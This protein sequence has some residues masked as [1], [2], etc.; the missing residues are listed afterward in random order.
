[1]S[2]RTSY[3]PGT[4]CWVDL[5]T[6]DL[7]AAAELLRRAVRLGDA[8]A[9]ELGRNG[10]LPAGE[11]ERQ[12]RRRGDAADAGGPAAGLEHLRL[13][14]RR[15]RDRRRGP[16]ERRH[17]D[18]R[19]DGR[20]STTASWRSSPTPRAPSSG[21]GSPARF[22]GAE[23][24]NEPG[25]FGWNELDTRDTAAAKEFYGAVFGW[26]FE[27]EESERDGHY[28]VW[29]ARRRDRSAACST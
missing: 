27:D 22:A 2:E 9:A 17:G 21:S 13:G 16:G 23:L 19:A 15:R 7:E 1:M 10:R 25:A 8:G 3:A 6:P 12:G 18:R 24:V 4:P 29:K 26:A 20:A 28:T 14:R 5:A 11:N